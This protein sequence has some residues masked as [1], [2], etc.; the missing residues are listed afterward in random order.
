M[1]LR[2]AGV[3]NPTPTPT[4]IL[5]ILINPAFSVLLGHE[6]GEIGEISQGAPLGVLARACGV[7]CVFTK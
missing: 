1:R 7:V 4:P 5:L 6:V 3:H 2:R